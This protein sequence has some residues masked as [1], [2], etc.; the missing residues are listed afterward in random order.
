MNR[1]KIVQ[2]NNKILKKNNNNNQMF[3]KLR[4]SKIIKERIK[5]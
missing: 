2:I 4:L 5:K 1:I 3:L